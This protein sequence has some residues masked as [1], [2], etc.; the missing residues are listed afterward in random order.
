MEYFWG[1]K[2]S[3]VKPGTEGYVRRLHRR[4][5]GRTLTTVNPGHEAEAVYIWVLPTT[6]RGVPPAYKDYEE[7]VVWANVHYF[8]GTYWCYLYNL[9]GVVGDFLGAT[10]SQHQTL[11]SALRRARKAVGRFAPKAPGGWTKEFMANVSPLNSIYPRT[12]PR[13]TRQGM[14][15][16]YDDFLERE[17]LDQEEVMF[18]K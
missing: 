9:P 6:T 11:K 3:L 17:C 10:K 4:I 5:L 15:R 1:D 18:R 12:L 13:Y 16:Y 14:D 8:E 2:A 7:N